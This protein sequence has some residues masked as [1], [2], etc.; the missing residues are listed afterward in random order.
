M[1]VFRINT[2]YEKQME[3]LKFAIMGAGLIA[4]RF[5]DAVDLLEDCEVVAVS[6][7]SMDRAKDF[8]ERHQLEYCFN[9]YEE[10]LEVVRPDG[11]YIAVTP[12]DHYRLT[13]MCLKRNIPVLC[14][15]AMFMNSKEAEEVF[16][17]SRKHNIFVMEAL[18]SRFL[19][20]IK[21][22]K[23]W[24]ADGKIGTPIFI[25]VTLGYIP[26]EG[27][28]DR[29]FRKDLGGGAARDLLCY[30]Y[31][32]TTFLVDQPVEKA[33]V[34]PIWGETG[35]DATEHVVLRFPTA[36]A[37]LTCSFQVPMEDRLVVYGTDGK[38]VIPLPHYTREAY[39]YNKKKEL[40]DCLK[41]DFTVNGFTY[42]IQETV[43]CIR[44]NKYESEVVPHQSTL[45]C[46]KLFD[47]LEERR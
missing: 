26:K 21:L 30:A 13:M 5:C 41:D 27:T 14:E 2:S 15:K 29:F 17:Y 24:I 34:Y 18:W 23:S 43:N 7:K 8:A 45:E 3:K 1:D 39:L 11:V 10:M 36:I 9:D 40:V 6:S 19:P 32:I 44:Q 20:P 31:E 12:N 4:N 42:E 25:E 16:E 22:S 47:M 37:A 33:E 28:G 38:V 35:V 46:S